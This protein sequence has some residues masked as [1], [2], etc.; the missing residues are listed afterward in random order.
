MKETEY[1]VR[2]TYQV[3]RF[4]AMDVTVTELR[5]LVADNYDEATFQLVCAAGQ[6]P[7]GMMIPLSVL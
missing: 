7:S 4:K 2:P 6:A 1:S 3:W 5:S